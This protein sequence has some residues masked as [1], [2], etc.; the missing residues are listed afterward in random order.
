M[1]KSHTRTHVHT[2]AKNILLVTPT[3]LNTTATNEACREKHAF[4][5][6]NLTHSFINSFIDK[7]WLCQ[8]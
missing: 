8:I 3:G 4:D 6:I 5:M 7:L 1:Y 2:H